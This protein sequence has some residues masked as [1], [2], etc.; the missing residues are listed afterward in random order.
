VH[1][2]CSL[3]KGSI[4]DLDL[5]KRSGK[6]ATVFEAKSSVGAVKAE[7]IRTQIVAA[8]ALYGSAS[9]IMLALPTLSARDRQILNEKFAAAN[10]DVPSVTEIT[11]E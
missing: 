4:T 6:H 3:C 2:I 7:Q 5:V 1:V 8:K 11:A 9:T 10:M